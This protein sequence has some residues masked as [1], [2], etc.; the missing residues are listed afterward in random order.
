MGSGSGIHSGQTTAGGSSS[1]SSRAGPNDAVAPRFKLREASSD[2]QLRFE[3][4]FPGASDA[5]DLVLEVSPG[6]IRVSPSA[7]F[8]IRAEEY[9][10]AAAPDSVEVQLPFDVDP[11]SVR[12]GF[13]KRHSRL[14]VHL[15]K[16]VTNT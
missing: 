9:S 5:D 12:A 6:T 7:A 11:A 10:Y 1:S 4:V 2:G 8:L 15:T 3:C 13:K 16:A 14:T